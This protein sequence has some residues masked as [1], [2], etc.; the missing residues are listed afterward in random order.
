M[1]WITLILLA[2]STL[3]SGRIFETQFKFSLLGRNKGWVY[4]DKMTFAPGAATVEI[5]TFT[6]G[7]PYGRGSEIFLQAVKSEKW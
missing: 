6:T 7:L 1:T 3:S 4:L 2:L 5:E